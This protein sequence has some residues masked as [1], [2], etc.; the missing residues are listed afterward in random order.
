MKSSARAACAC[1]IARP[2][3]GSAPEP[4]SNSSANAI[5]TPP[6]DGGGL[7][8]TSRPRYVARTGSRAIGS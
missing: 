6:E 4:S 8:R 7:V 2:A 3:T 5:S 1:S